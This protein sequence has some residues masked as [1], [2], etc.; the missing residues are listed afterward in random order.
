MLAQSILSGAIHYLIPRKYSTVDQSS[1]RMSILM[2]LYSPADLT[3]NMNMIEKFFL[4]GTGTGNRPKPDPQSDALIPMPSRKKAFKLIIGL[5]F[6][7]R[8]ASVL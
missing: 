4:S 2:R 1:D 8:Y 5:K 3:G 7:L 6:G